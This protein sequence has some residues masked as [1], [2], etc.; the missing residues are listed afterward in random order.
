MRA[1]VAGLGCSGTDVRRPA[2]VSRGGSIHTTHAGGIAYGSTGGLVQADVAGEEQGTPNSD[3]EYCLGY[4]P[5]EWDTERVGCVSAG[6]SV[7]HGS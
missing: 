7:W 6:H 3:T 1:C 5:P 4:V 2:T